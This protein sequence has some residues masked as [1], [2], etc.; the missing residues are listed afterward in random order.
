[1]QT[2]QDRPTTAKAPEEPKKIPKLKILIG[3]NSCWKDLESNQA[4][5]DT[6]AQYVPPEWDLRFF[7]GSRNF[8]DE[9]Q[10]QLFTPEMIGSPGT[11]GNLAPITAKKAVIG[12][13]ED[14][15][16]DEILIDCP[17]SYLGLPWKTNESLKWALERGYDGVI[18][19]FTDTYMFPDR[20]VQADFRKYD[21]IGWSFGCGPC[22]A[23]PHSMHSCPLGGAAYWLS[24][25]AAK[26][27]LYLTD[28][29][30]TGLP[31]APRNFEQLEEKQSPENERGEETMASPNQAQGLRNP[32]EPLRE[33]QNETQP[34]D[35]SQKR[36]W[37]PGSS[38]RERL[39]L[40]GDLPENCERNRAGSIPDSLSPLQ[41][42]ERERTE[43]QNLV[44]RP[45]RHWG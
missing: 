2:D 20:F 45:I 44:A 17:D 33:L 38:E 6:W 39:N 43:V 9:E 7:L 4:I 10:A 14:L 22:P 15:K 31:S 42:G 5:R 32:R 23:H 16:D 8:T 26:A 37:P 1:M 35:R 11:L 24:A 28:G 40:S 30:D 13:A 3:V 36:R 25:K 12:S 34:A 29:E 27:V 18:R 21:A 19:A 41:L